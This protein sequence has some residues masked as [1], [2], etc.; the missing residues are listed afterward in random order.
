[1]LYFQC[2]CVCAYRHVRS[3]SSTA[4]LGFRIHQSSTNAKITQLDLPFGIQQDIRWLHVS[5]NH[6]VFLLQVQQSFNNLNIRGNQGRE[7]QNTN[8]LT[9][10]YVNLSTM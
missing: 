2:V 9:N 1:M 7:K 8:N 5:V 3:T 10:I 4:S 6:T